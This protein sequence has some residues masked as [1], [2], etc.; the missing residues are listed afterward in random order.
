MRAHSHT[1]IIVRRFEGA[2]IPEMFITGGG[3]PQMAQR[4]DLLPLPQN[5]K[6]PRGIEQSSSETAG[7]IRGFKHFWVNILARL[8]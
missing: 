3:C 7:F 8:A 5:E 1:H 6:S 2:F 4:P